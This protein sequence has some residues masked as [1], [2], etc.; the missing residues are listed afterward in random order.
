MSG[1]D[2]GVGGTG[3]R[4]VIAVWLAA[5]AM[6]CVLAAPAPASSP[7]EPPADAW[8]LVDAGDGKVLAARAA[9]RAAPIASA[10]KLMTAYVA[11]QDLRLSEPIVAPAYAGAPVESLLGLRDG[12]RIQVRDLLAG[13]LLAS[14]NDA[15][16]ALAEASAGSV[17][18]FVAEMNRA[19]RRLGL[20]QTSYANPIGLDEP[21]NHSSAEDLATLAIE[22]RRD[23]F[24]RRLF[25]RPQ[26]RL[27]SGATTR[28]IANRNE[29]VRTVP[30]VDGVKT[31]R[32]LDAGHVLVGSGTRKGVT[33][34]SVVLGAPS[35]AARDAGTLELLRHGFSL[36]Q[37]HAAVE[38]SEHLAEPRVS[39]RDETLGLLA[40]RALAITV[41]EGQDVEIDVAAPGEIEGPVERGERLGRAVVLV[42]GEPAGEVALVAARA[43]PSATLVE[44]LDEIVPG[45]RFLLWAVVAICVG[46]GFGGIVVVVDR[47]RARRRGNPVGEESA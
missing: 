47:R 43:V 37:R 16:V 11:R 1:A 32:T 30:W 44:R 36:Y 9:D 17:S 13:L 12:E 25:D 18:R 8:V 21:G 41:R 10:T 28:R 45:P 20:E 4:A 24:F 19:A 42:D 39:Y 27:R 5:I 29:L 34:V 31:G 46:V 40:A 15:A 6:L 22:L 14:G 35:E 23:P 7:P 3:I 33:L 2:R 26:A 38:R